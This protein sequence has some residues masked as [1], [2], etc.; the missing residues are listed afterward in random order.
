MG[1]PKSD[2][3]DREQM[4]QLGSLQQQQPRERGAAGGY[5]SE[6]VPWASGSF[7]LL[8]SSPIMEEPLLQINKC[9][10]DGETAAALSADL[11]L[12]VAT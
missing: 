3:S 1:K 6:K 9:Q 10:E 4:E 12:L 2:R 5:Y 8:K 7:L 11:V